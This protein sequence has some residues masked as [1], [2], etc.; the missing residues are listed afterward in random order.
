MGALAGR[1]EGGGEE[2]DKKKTVCVKRKGRERES[3][4]WYPLDFFLLSVAS[5]PVGVAWKGIR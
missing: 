3:V 5:L 1:P 4:G 2:G